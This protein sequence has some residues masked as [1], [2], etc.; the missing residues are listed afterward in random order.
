MSEIASSLVPVSKH[1]AQLLLEAGYLWLDL[2]SADKAREVF[3]G[4]AALMP[5]SEV[6]QLALGT[7]EF[8]LGRHEKALQAYRAAGRLSPR[9]GLPRAHAAEALLFMGKVDEALKEIK[10]AIDADPEGDGA[11]LAQ[12]LLEAKEAGALPPPK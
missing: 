5:R 1:Q 11:R 3:L 7:L 10:A 12:A 6:P 8:C 2:G 9:S 4:V